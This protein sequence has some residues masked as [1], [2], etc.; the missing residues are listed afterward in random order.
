MTDLLTLAPPALTCAND[1]AHTIYLT[2]K[3][4]TLTADDLLVLLAS[5]DVAGELPYLLADKGAA[6]DWRTRD[7]PNAGLELTD[8]DWVLGAHGERRCARCGGAVR[9]WDGGA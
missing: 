4:C 3:G 2:G 6:L 1:S 9:E 7:C 8:D 5:D